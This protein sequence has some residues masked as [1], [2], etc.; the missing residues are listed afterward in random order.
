MIRIFFYFVVVLIASSTAIHAQTHH[1]HAHDKNGVCVT[2]EVIEQLFGNDREYQKQ[3]EEVEAWIDDYIANNPPTEVKGANGES[4][5]VHRIPVV[6]HVMY[7]TEED[8]ISKYQI[9]D[10]LRVLNE[11]YRRKN[12]DTV[13][14]RNVFLSRAADYEV[15]FHLARVDPSGNCTEG[16]NRVKTREAAN[17]TNNIK[18]LS[19]WNN[20]KYLNI[21]TVRAISSNI[22]QGL[23]LGYA[24]FPQPNQSGFNDGVLQ[25]HDR[26][27]SVGT[28]VS[29]GRTLTHEV[30]H[31]LN[32]H[33]P[34]HNGCGGG[35]FVG[36]TPPAAQANF[37]CNPSTNS[38]GGAFPDM[39]EN[40]MDYS[41]DDC[42]NTFTNGQKS[43]SKAVLNNASLRGD[44]AA[45]NNLKATGVV[46]G[47]VCAPIADFFA[48]TNVVCSGD[49]VKFVDAAI[50]ANPDEYTWYFENGTPATSN[51]RYPHVVYHQEGVHRVSLVV[52]NDAGQDSISIRNSVWVKYDEPSPFQSWLREN[53]EGIEIPNLN[54][55]LH[56]LGSTDVPVK[57]TNDASFSGTRSALFGLHETDEHGIFRLVSPNIDM[58]RATS[59]V[60]EFKYAHA[61]KHNDANT[62]LRVNISTDCGKTWANR[63]TI[64]GAMLATAPPTTGNFVPQSQSEWSSMQVSLA[65]FAGANSEILIMFEV[66]N[67]GGNNL[68][69]DEI[70]MDVVLSDELGFESDQ[71]RFDAFP[72][73]ATESL[74]V[75]LQSTSDDTSKLTLISVTGQTVWQNDVHLAAGERTRID[76][77]D[78]ANFPAGVYMLRHDNATGREVKKII[79]Q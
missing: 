30:G 78:F 75:E 34:F 63:R 4:T 68:Y 77:A 14:L 72:N 5:N 51:E 52:K 41:N 57:V 36:D 31:Y 65:Q 47:D 48:Q 12:A 79:K 42:Q 2:D 45:T 10:A 6:F 73:P 7:D 56:R 64:Q 76:V 11:D 22:S 1:N 50:G 49:T 9:M 40:Y 19:M 20:K 15:E 46:G 59:A 26:T 60:L 24:F 62:V 43:R 25:R 35:D 33:H 69:I 16:I 55:S 32:L 18:R 29:L 23:L 44:V 61:P 70:N 58:T 39:I 13:N 37:G 67:A 38:C 8:N 71:R 3:R 17:S 66:E 74:T 21:W 53:F 27:G 54:W 28:S